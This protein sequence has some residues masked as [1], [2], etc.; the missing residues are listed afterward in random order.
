MKTNSG[1]FRKWL[2]GCILLILFSPGAM[3]S[4]QA[5]PQLPGGTKQSPKPHKKVLVVVEGNY[6][7]KNIATAEGREI[8]TLLGHFNT[9]TTMKG[10]TQYTPQELQHFDCIF[11]V[12]KSDSHTVPD[13]FAQDVLKTKRTVVWMNTGMQ[14]LCRIQNGTARLGFTI[15]R[16]DKETPYTRVTSGKST[17]TRRETALNIV[18]VKDRRKVSV[19]ANAVAAK[20]GATTPYIV[21]SDNFYYF[22]DMPVTMAKETDRYLLFADMLH[23]ILKEP[24]RG[25]HLALLRIEDVN[26]MSNADRLRD[27]ADILSE[28][29]IPF[30]VGVVP[31]YVN[32]SEDLRITLS[33]KPEIVD[34]LKYMV[35]NGGTI[36]MHGVTHQYR[37]NSTDDFEF[38]D[39]Q[40]GSPIKDERADD[41]ERKIELGLDEFMKNG[42]YPLLW[43]T[44]HYTASFLTYRTV[45]KYFSTAVEQRLAIENIDYGQY[46]P[47]IIY[48]D[49][50]GQKIYPENLG[51][52]PLT[53]DYDRG[54]EYVKTLLSN[55]RTMLQV[56][57]GF[58]SCFFHPFI[59]PSLLEELVDGIQGMGYQYIDVRDSGNWVKA[60]DKVILSGTQSYA[61]K[62]NNSFLYEAYF[63]QDGDII[64]K[65]VSQKRITGEVRKRVVL[66]PGQIYV[67]EPVEYHE[68]EATLGDRIVRTA[69]E[70][71]REIVSPEEKWDEAHV[72]LCMNQAARGGFYNNQVSFEALFRSLNINTRKIYLGDA[73]DLRGCNLLVI[74]YAY[75]STMRKSQ[76]QEVAQFVRRGG[77]LVTDRKSE[78]IQRLGFRFLDTRA[79]IFRLSDRFHPHEYIYWKYPQLTS[80]LDLEM[81][82]EVFCE[83]AI[84]GV[85]VVVGREL[86]EGKILYFNAPFDPDS[87][88]GYSHYPYAYEY[89]RH[90]FNLLP[91]VRRENL[92]IY[93]DPG[94][95]QT[96]SVESLVQMWVKNGV[97]TVHVSGWHQY[98]KYTY[99]YGR[100]IRL[101]HGNGIM[102]H[103][104]LEPPQVS[105]RF[106]NDH[107]EWREKNLL[108]QD[109][110]PSW[111]YPVALTDG[112]CFDAA[113]DEYIGLLRKFDFDGV[114]LAELYFESDGGFENPE[115]YTPFHPSAQ[116]EIQR[117]YNID[118]Q[119]AF[120]PS[121]NQYYLKNG[122]VRATITRYRTEKITELH[123][124]MLKRLYEFAREREGFQIMVTTMDSIGS[125]ELTENIGIDTTALVHLQRKY[126]F[127]L[128]VEDPESRWSTTP[129]RYKQIGEQYA[130]LMG[131]EEK[132]LVDLNILNFRRKNQITPFPTLIQTGIESYQMVHYSALGAPRFTIYSEATVNPQDLSLF[133]YASSSRVKYTRTDSGYEVESPHSFVLKLPNPTRIVHIDGK[134]VIGS[135]GNQFL[136][137]AGR[138]SVTLHRS[139]DITGFSTVEL[140]PQVVSF[141]GNLLDVGYTMRKILIKYESGERALIS[142]NS[143]INRVRVD[144][145]P[146][147]FQALH[148]NDCHS[149]YL[150]AGTHDVEIE[151]VSGFVYGI[152]VT[153]LWWTKFIAIFGSVAVVMLLLMYFALK[154]I[155]RRAEPG[156]A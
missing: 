67:A 85:P 3:R 124:R 130:K 17:F 47:Y 73:L 10:S 142:V 75:A 94:L 144:G 2:L 36:V 81:G 80:K 105:Q 15:S 107:P 103:A 115:N 98:P 30:L 108:G 70:L 38:W 82:D 137:P 156:A 41:I 32:T 20:G 40:I 93:Y 4:P 6:S 149:M 71:Y 43:E 37:G 128:Q 89:I 123:E 44:P 131:G 54:E 118:L 114:N 58:A 96:T 146:Y 14:E 153:S 88:L 13:H 77:N 140:Q 125:P 56:R 99:D 65:S 116:R 19:L 52:V 97:R 136:V 78:L 23:D 50:F 35:R 133:P 113:M 87:E 63:D 48:R 64:R 74:P 84:S 134:A 117:R 152:D 53:P 29:E 28:R 121:S 111:R 12:G 148:G 1:S 51:Y 126:G 104:W 68:K 61:I 39:G 42:L 11:Y 72:V 25:Q 33:D 24:H 46:Y 91:V 155:R 16:I 95:R 129:A 5:H 141:S 8:A 138:H 49:F 69:R 22:A 9:E 45:A 143:E 62:L 21:K 147:Q 150:P 18:K 55:A 154:L 90:F 79:K 122:A 83:S 145:E 59:D 109:I 110:R 34:A 92:E 120:N 26:P 101:A 151:T 57:D 7:L 106:W 119:Q 112:K 27:I 66:E 139:E 102:V 31:V 127:H 86:G 135:R 132:L 100:L 76:I 60:R